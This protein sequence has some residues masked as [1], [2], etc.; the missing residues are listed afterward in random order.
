LFFVF[1]FVFLFKERTNMKL[2]G[3]GTLE[4]QG[5]VGENEKIKI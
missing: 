5:V 3:W 4:K 1:G 2:G